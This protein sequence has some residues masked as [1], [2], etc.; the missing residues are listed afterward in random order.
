MAQ[1]VNP[2]GALARKVRRLGHLDL[3]GAGQV[4]V[5]GHHAYVGHI[6]NKDNLGTSI[7]DIA[8]PANPKLVATV[9]LD[10][11]TSHSHKV[12]VA[13]G[14][15][16]VN[17]E[18]NMTPIGRRAE[19]M[20]AARR[21]LQAALGREPT[22][23]ELA[24]KLNVTEAV[25]IEV[26]EAEKKPYRNGGFRIY[27]VANPAR[28]SLIHHQLTGGI[29]VH[30]F[31]MDERYAYI[32]TEMDGFIGNILVT[33]DLK[34][35]K[36]PQEVSR[37]WMPGQNLAAGETPSWSGKR[38][39]LHH[40][41]RFGD[42]MWASCWHGGFRI[43]DV[44]DLAKPKT[45]GAY[46][47]HPPFPEPTHTAMPVPVAISGRRIALSIDEEDQAQ[48]ANEEEARRGRLHAGMATYDVTDPADIKPLALFDV[49]E[50]DTPFARTPGARFGAH[51]FHERM[52]GTLVFAVWFS[53]G[54]RVVDVAD[55]SSPRE[56]GFFIPEPV[57][58]HKA[59]QSND[60]VLDGRGLIYMVDRLNGFDVLEFNGG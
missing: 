17:H 47:Y 27:D 33:Y 2:N 51:Q 55:P 56:V 43:V 35:P 13:G 7:I 45:I 28:P 48:S 1:S 40:A 14:I 54:L 29:G 53:G 49:S 4:T 8:D 50:L 12:R 57:A 6:P 39:R 32:S 21:E 60:V 22:R 25:M 30:R 19:Q 37:W 44:S 26:E 20:P 36:R 23:G 11:P 41:L 59:P 3:P 31:D 38:H 9:T 5:A 16:V 15:M 58:G 46:N 52:T 18:R 10:D 24:V 42:E 34:D